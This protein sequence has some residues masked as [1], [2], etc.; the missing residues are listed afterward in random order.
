M[1]PVLDR[2]FKAGGYPLVEGYTRDDYRKSWR[3]AGRVGRRAAQGRRDRS[4]PAPTG[5]GSNWFVRSSFTRRPASHRPKRCRPRRSSRR[6]WSAPTSAPARSRSARKPTWCW[7]TATC[8]TTSARCAGSSRSSATAMSWTATRCARRRDI[9]GRPKIESFQ[10]G[11]GMRIWG[12]L[13]VAAAAPLMLTGCLWGPGKFTSNLAL[14]KA[15]TFVL[16]YQGEIMIQIPDDKTAAGPVERRHGGLPC[17]RT[18]PSVEAALGH[19]VA[20]TRTRSTDVGGRKRERPCT[21]AEIAKL[22]ADYEKTGREK[23]AEQ[24]QGNRADGQAVRPARTRRRVQP[25]LRR[26]AHEVSGLAVG[27]LQGEGRVRRRLSFRR[28]ADPGL[29][30]PDDARQRHADPVHHAIAGA[31]DG[32]VH[33]DR[34]GTDRRHGAVRRPRQDDGPARQ[35]Q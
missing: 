15:G 6:E 18:A 13:V 32:S 26:Q 28:P 34:S 24:A 9:S 27:H 16:D 10:R 25:P 5:R 35:G 29:R 1:S 20:R 31:A 2:Y 4:S 7:S 22:K 23:R 3:Q 21:A 19:G 11:L 14:N 33:G 8:R 12:K 30:L 17:R